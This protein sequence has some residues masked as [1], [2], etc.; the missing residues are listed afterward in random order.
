MVPA[1]GRDP[2]RWLAAALAVSTPCTVLPPWL[3]PPLSPL[4]A[5][6][7]TASL[8]LRDDCATLAPLS[9]TPLGAPP[10]QAYSARG[11]SSAYVIIDKHLHY[12]P[13]PPPDLGRASE[14]AKR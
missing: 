9:K 13:T 12:L 14:G 10:A 3:A 5:A 4:C 6:V 1:R 8:Q 7:S 2:P 11:A